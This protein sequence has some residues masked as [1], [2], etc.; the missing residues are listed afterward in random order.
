MKRLRS[1]LGT[2]VADAVHAVQFYE[3]DDYLIAALS[4]FVAVGL[5]AGEAAIVI[6]TRDHR[7]GLERSLA[8]R[9]VDVDQARTSGAYVPMEAT[10]LLPRLM[11]G[12]TIEAARFRELVGGAIG[13]A[14]GANGT[15]RVR[16]FGEMVGLL[17]A[18]GNEHAA[19]QLEGL[20]GEL[21]RT[22]SIALVCAYPTALFGDVAE[23]SVGPLRIAAA[24]D[25]DTAP[26]N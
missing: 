2:A 15:R 16:V 20:W 12:D 21:T 3:T 6:A 7:L 17:W 9:G 1:A 25:Q 19:L 18:A 10:E 14:R 26:A 4:E 23:P 22:T 13:R 24:H 5:I 11:A 8:R